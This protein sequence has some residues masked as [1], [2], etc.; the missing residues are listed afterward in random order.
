MKE[1]T[2]YAKSVGV[3]VQAV[4]KGVVGNLDKMNMYNFEGGING[5]TK[6]AAQV[7]D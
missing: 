7:Q 6:M 2:D 5:L 3:S 1:V 4:S